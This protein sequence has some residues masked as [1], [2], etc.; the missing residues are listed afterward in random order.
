MLSLTCHSL[1]TQGA[2]AP[3]FGEDITLLGFGPDYDTHYGL[4]APEQTVLVRAYSDD[5]DD[6][7]LQEM[8]PRFI[9]MFEPNLEF[10]RRIEVRTDLP[11]DVSRMRTNA[12]GI[13]QL[14]P[15]FG[16]ASILHDVQA[17]LRRRQ[18]PDR[19]ETREG[20]LRASH[21]GARGMGTSLDSSP[22]D[23]D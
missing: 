10:I 2:L 9:V 16:S 17:Q 1:S 13:P 20:G 11:V 18:V 23:A 19:S 12:P 21:Q 15:R 5:S 8:Q 4:L 14:E 3:E 6:R 22:C 7:M